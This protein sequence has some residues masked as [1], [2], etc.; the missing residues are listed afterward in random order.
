M[1]SKSGQKRRPSWRSLKLTIPIGR[2]TSQPE[3]HPSSIGDLHPA[4]LHGR[5]FL[6]LLFLLFFSHRV[7]NTRGHAHT[8]SHSF[9][10]RLGFSTRTSLLPR[11]IHSHVTPQRTT[12][13]IPPIDHLRQ[14]VVRTHVCKRNVCPRITVLGRLARD[15]TRTHRAGWIARGNVVSTNFNTYTI[16]GETK[17]KIPGKGKASERRYPHNG[18]P[19]PVNTFTSSHRT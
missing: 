17:N 18:R 13:H 8:I 2:V 7:S 15:G 6:F 16:A 14:Y 12:P 11:L 5:F 4:P 19:L 9:R 1:V 3:C 10:T